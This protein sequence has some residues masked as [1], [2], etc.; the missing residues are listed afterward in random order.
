MYSC[1]RIISDLSGFIPHP[2][3]DVLFSRNDLIVFAM[4][5]AILPISSF[6]SSRGNRSNTSVLWSSA[7]ALCRHVRTNSQDFSR[8]LS[9]FL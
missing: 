7:K 3:A 5:V 6:L 8:S 1:G 2:A 9:D 4:R